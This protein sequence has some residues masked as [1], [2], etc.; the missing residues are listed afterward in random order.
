MRLGNRRGTINR[1]ILIVS[2]FAVFLTLVLDETVKKRGRK[3][4]KVDEEEG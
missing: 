1:M 4:R 2:L 3:E